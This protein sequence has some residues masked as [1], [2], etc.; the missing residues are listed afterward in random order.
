MT[1]W[2]RLIY[3]ISLWRLIGYDGK[4]TTWR[5]AWDIAGALTMAF[6]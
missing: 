6:P 2:R 5:D 1:T 3:A 4:P